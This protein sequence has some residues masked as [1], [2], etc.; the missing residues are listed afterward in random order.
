MKFEEWSR[1]CFK[2]SNGST[3]LVNELKSYFSIRFHEQIEKGGGS[4]NS[5]FLNLHMKI[6][7]YPWA[8]H[9]EKKSESAH[10]W[11]P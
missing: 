2:I 5:N 1:H 4:E 3:N 6:T 8:P 7:N 10:G 9:L 11:A